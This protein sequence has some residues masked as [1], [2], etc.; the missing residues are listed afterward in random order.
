[1][2]TYLMILV[3]AHIQ[4]NETVAFEMDKTNN[5]TDNEL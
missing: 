5:E 1:M 2:E 3:I 4:R